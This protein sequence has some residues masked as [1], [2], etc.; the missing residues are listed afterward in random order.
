MF[1][2]LSVATTHVLVRT[3]NLL[4]LG[5]LLARHAL[6]FLTGGFLT[7]LGARARLPWAR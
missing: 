1:R 6:R 4:F 7:I 3:A 5:S 2:V